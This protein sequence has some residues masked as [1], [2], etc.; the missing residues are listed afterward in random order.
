M[1]SAH[2]LEIPNLESL[3][4]YPLRLT[5]CSLKLWHITST[6]TRL[7]AYG[8]SVLATLKQTALVSCLKR[9]TVTGDCLN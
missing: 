2:Q 7:E 3:Q 6:T 4:F 8:V 9:L 5:V 1:I